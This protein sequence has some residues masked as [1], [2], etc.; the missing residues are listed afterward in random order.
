MTSSRS[1]S[2]IK[3]IDTLKKDFLNQYQSKP[4]EPR[5][6]DH[7]HILDLVITNEAVKFQIFSKKC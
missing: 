2:E 3:F 7:P 5:G 1:G 6:D 4:T